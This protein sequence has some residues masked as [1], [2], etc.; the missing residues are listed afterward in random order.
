MR[1][2]PN[3]TALTRKTQTHLALLVSAAALALVA[4]GG[5]GTTSDNGA[6]ASGLRALPSNFSALR[7][8]AYSPYRTATSVDDRA[9]ETITD[10]MVKQDLDLLVASGFG[11][12]RI[13]DSSDKVAVRTLRVIAA[14]NIDL[15]VMLGIYVNSFEYDTNLS[16][17]AKAAIMAANEE[18]IARGVALANSY[19][20]TV[21]A[22]S[23]GNETQVD[24]SFVQISSSQ[25]AKYLKS[26]RSQIAQPVTTDDNYAVFAG[27]MPH[28]PAA[29]Q[30]SEVLAQI[31]FASIHSYPI[32]DVYYSNTSD[33]DAWPDWDWRQSSASAMMDAAV[34]KVQK[35]Y[36]LA[37]AYMDIKGKSHMPI[38]IGETGWR[39]ADPSGTDRFRFLASPV[40]QKMYYDRLLAWADASVS[41][42]GPK[43]IVYFEAFD[44]PWKGSD[45]KWGLFNVNRQARYAVQAKNAPSSTWVYEYK[46]GTTPY[47]DMDAVYFQ[48][49]VAKA[50]VTANRYTLY[51]SASTSGEV[52]ASTLTSD[53]QW[54]AFDGGTATRNENDTA[55]DLT[56]NYDGS[57]SLS[58]VPNPASYGWGLLSHSAT[59]STDNLSAFA[60]AGTLNFSVKTQY[61][62][63]IRIG[64]STDTD[65]RSGAQ[66]YVTLTNGSYGYCNTGAWCNVSIP[67]TAFKAVNAKIDLRYVLNRFII[68]DIFSETG[69]TSQTRQINLDAIYYA[70]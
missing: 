3:F 67:L 37:R 60:A 45:D 19:P 24:W 13:F 68:A 18:E 69:N 51:A 47:V 38:I 6:T 32:E 17:S 21:V 40:N 31:D 20:S 36:A 5:G 8:V 7:A 42:P 4:C 30:I 28:H 33:S 2:F 27:K 54:D 63:A 35:D 12:I 46:T 41:A 16:A 23:V 70:K 14:N 61:A 15:K 62:G 49:A 50:A 22:V 39:A 65:D 43:N 11:L 48:A 29:N 10:A 55:T 56:G 25:L 1:F 34:A 64:I 66:A 53:M 52:R 57:P 58:I 9:N 59:N 26:V 44:E